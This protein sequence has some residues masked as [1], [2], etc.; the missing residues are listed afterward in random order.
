[1]NVYMIFHGRGAYQA[2]DWSVKGGM[3]FGT[4]AGAKR[5]IDGAIDKVR[6]FRELRVF[7]GTVED[8]KVTY[9]DVSSQGHD[10]VWRVKE[11]WIIQETEIVS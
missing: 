5:A 7:M 3:V 1:M 4:F 10:W 11:H 9:F 2:E 8:K 6:E